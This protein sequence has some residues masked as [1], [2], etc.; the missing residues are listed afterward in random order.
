[1]E[2]RIKFKTDDFLGKLNIDAAKK[3][4]EAME[5][6]FVKPSSSPFTTTPYS[7]SE[8]LK[9]TKHKSITESSTVDHLDDRVIY[10]MNVAGFKKENLEI[11]VQNLELRITGKLG[12]LQGS[13]MVNYRFT[14]PKDVDLEKASVTLEDGILRIAIG[15]KAVKVTKLHINK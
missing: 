9:L 4:T 1:M 11:D 13:S 10:Y 7:T 2:N 8:L 15:R 3:I 5:S 14:L 6:I 12:G